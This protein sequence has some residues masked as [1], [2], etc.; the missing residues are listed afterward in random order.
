MFFLVFFYKCLGF[1]VLVLLTAH[2]E[3]FSVSRVQDF[4]F[5]KENKYLGYGAHLATEKALLNLKGL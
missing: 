3:R 1:K 4:N 2:V 5:G